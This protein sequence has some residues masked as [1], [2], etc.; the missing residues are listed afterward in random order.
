MPDRSLHQVP[1]TVRINDRK[2]DFNGLT[3][4]H[5]REDLFQA[6]ISLVSPKGSFAIGFY[7]SRSISAPKMDQE[8]TSP[9]YASPFTDQQQ[10]QAW[11][12][13][14]LTG[15]RYDKDHLKFSAGSTIAPRLDSPQI[16]DPNLRNETC[17]MASIRRLTESQAYFLRGGT[18]HLHVDQD[19]MQT[20]EKTLACLTKA[21]ATL[22]AQDPPFDVGCIVSKKFSCR[23]LNDLEAGCLEVEAESLWVEC[24]SEL[25]LPGYRWR[26]RLWIQF[27]AIGQTVECERWRSQFN[28][29]LLATANTGAY[30][31]G[32]QDSRNS[33]LCG[34]RISLRNAWAALRVLGRVLLAA[35]SYVAVAMFFKARVLEPPNQKQ[36]GDWPE[37]TYHHLESEDC[38]ETTY[39]HPQR[40]GCRTGKNMGIVSRRCIFVRTDFGLKLPKSN[41]DYNYSETMYPH[42]VSELSNSNQHQNH[43]ETTYLHPLIEDYS[44][45]TYL[46]LESKYSSL[47][48]CSEE[49]EYM[50]RLPTSEGQRLVCQNANLTESMACLQ[51][52]FEVTHEAL[53]TVLDSEPMS[54][55]SSLTL[56]FEAETLWSQHHTSRKTQVG[57]FSVDSA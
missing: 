33:L 24:R 9:A 18:L 16:A 2:P 12:P 25:E 3:H 32:F 53:S 56:I 13:E 31:S 22:N 30:T 55:N 37:T 50:Y 17:M 35:Q 39:L 19:T 44:K 23:S 15:T 36:H 54:D 43:A 45:T 38:T 14:N 52:R 40:R 34:K 48:K 11:R 51:G 57:L 26:L 42:P 47:N 4:H 5:S 7:E 10:R 49:F 27:R 8:C 46:C 21:T 20:M 28:G 1:E 6:K 41:Q 29:K